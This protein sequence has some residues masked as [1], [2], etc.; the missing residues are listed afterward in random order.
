MSKTVTTPIDKFA[1]IMDL[2][3]Q[4]YGEEVMK[5]TQGVVDAVGREGAKAVTATSKQAVHSRTY[6]K[7]W[8][9]TRQVDS[10]NRLLAYGVIHNKTEYRLV[11][12]LEKSHVARNGTGRTFGKTEPHPHVR[13]VEEQIIAK[14]GDDIVRAIK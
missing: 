4:A 1:H 12:L 11:H 8:T 14:L 10:H 2:T 5:L 3:L 7:G 9:Y 13:P 6:H